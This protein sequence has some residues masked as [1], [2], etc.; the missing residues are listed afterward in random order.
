MSDFKAVYE[1]FINL[2]IAAEELS[3]AHLLDPIERRILYILSTYW[4]KGK[5]ITVGES[6]KRID[7]LSSATT[8]KYIKQLKN[9]GYLQLVVDEK[10]NR[11]KYV[12]PTSLVDE[13]FS[14][15]GKHLIEAVNIQ[16][17]A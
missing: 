14:N 7:E 5:T 15:L 9:K 2:A 6:V 13:F 8:F 10:D 16:N 17:N 3:D 12:L 1:R 11:V 4:S